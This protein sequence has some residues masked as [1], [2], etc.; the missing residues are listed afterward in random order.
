MRLTEW[1]RGRRVGQNC[2]ALPP[3]QSS[4]S[5]KQQAPCTPSPSS[6]TTLP[7]RCLH[8][9]VAERRHPREGWLVS[10]L[11]GEGIRSWDKGMGTLKTSKSRSKAHT[12]VFPW[13]YNPHFGPLFLHEQNWDQCKSPKLTAQI[14]PREGG[15]GR[16][17]DIPPRGRKLSKVSLPRSVR[18]GG[19]SCL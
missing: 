14:G 12:L 17:L 1:K 5:L 11:P 13:L 6:P 10:P 18:G 16:M 2:T 7:Q 4:S 9:E 19:G 15:E 3:G 8:P